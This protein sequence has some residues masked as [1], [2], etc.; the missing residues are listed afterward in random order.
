MPT[1]RDLLWALAG[2]AGAAAV[3]TVGRRVLDLR[4]HARVSRDGRVAGT[5]DYGANNT[6]APY[7]HGA[8]A[9]T[10]LGPT[11]LDA[12][13]IPPP[14]GRGPVART[15]TITQ[16]PLD[17]AQ[18][19][20]MDAWTFDGG[21]PGPILRVTEG[22]TLTLTVRNL[23]EHPHNLH[24]HGAHAPGADGWEPIAPGGTRTYEFTPRPY[25][26]HPYHCDLVPGA[27][28]LGRGL[29]GMLIVDPPAGRVPATER[30]LVLGGFDVDG[31]GRSELFGW[32]GVAGYF[33]RHPIKVR[34]GELVRLY[35]ANLVVDEPVATFHLH[36][37][38][39]GVIRAGTAMT[40]SEVTDVAAMTVGE[41][42][43][44]EM[45]FM[46]AGRYMFHP[47]QGRMA[48]AGGM[49]W[50]AVG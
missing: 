19:V 43:V 31:D 18:G 39:F 16:R 26:L 33:A 37:N 14:P 49:G 29:Y 22:E 13:T 8:E 23:T 5:P 17:I 40:P 6:H 21:V 36:A 30:A 50:I 9:P 20:T 10:R 7:G 45:R 11:A 48:E 28:H 2:A 42:V 27:E 4:T 1:R 24:A 3:G 47:H 35:V 34:R 38:T 15:I 44:L 46:E 32:N 25:G 12:V 41:R